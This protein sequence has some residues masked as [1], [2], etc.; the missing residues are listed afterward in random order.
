MQGKSA[1]PYSGGIYKIFK[2]IKGHIN[3]SRGV[4]GAY[5]VTQILPPALKLTKM[6]S[7]PE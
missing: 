5:V 4:H 6:L 1:K 2:R 7:D 3:I